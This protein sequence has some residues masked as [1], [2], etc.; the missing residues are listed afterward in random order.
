MRAPRAKSGPWSTAREW[1]SQSSNF[2]ELNSA[3]N[4]SQL[5]RGPRVL[6][7]IVSLAATLM[8]AW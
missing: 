4:L 3:N 2:K 6:C 1:A 8:S 5:R 7:E